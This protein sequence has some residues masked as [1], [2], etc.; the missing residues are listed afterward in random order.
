[1][2]NVTLISA[3]NCP[4]RAISNRSNN[5]IA[6]NHRHAHHE[7]AVSVSSMW[8]RHRSGGAL[9]PTRFRVAGPT[10]S[11]PGQ[12]GLFLSALPVGAVDRPRYMFAA[13]RRLLRRIGII[14]L[15]CR[16]LLAGAGAEGFQ[17]V[18]LR[19][20]IATTSTET[21]VSEIKGLLC[22]TQFV[23]NIIQ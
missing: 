2:R 6:G 19:Q 8:H 1:M 7:I 9:P 21:V 17:F 11:S 15:R 14:I 16:Q 5:C 22:P 10:F 3:R 20:Q 18:C 23:A 4:A 13:D 12:S